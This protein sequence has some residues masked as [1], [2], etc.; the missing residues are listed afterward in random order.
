MLPLR[1]QTFDAIAN[2]IM[3]SLPLNQQQ[4]AKY[5]SQGPT[6]LQINLNGREIAKEIYSD[7]NEFQERE[8]ERLK[9]F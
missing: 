9:V 3:G 8:K 6:V 5:V 7:V 1:K 2:G 4:G